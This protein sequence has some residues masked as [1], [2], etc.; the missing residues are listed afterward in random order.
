[1]PTRYFYQT[2]LHRQ[3]IERCIERTYPHATYTR[4]E[5]G[6]LVLTPTPNR[7]TRWSSVA[8]PTNPLLLPPAAQPISITLQAGDSMYLPA[9]WWHHVRQNGITIA[10]NWWY[11]LEV[12]GMSWVWLNFL[13]GEVGESQEANEVL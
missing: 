4:S 9:G 2:G 7:T 12:R 6:S 10:L 3:N 1:V 8:D 11:D 13:R 5:T